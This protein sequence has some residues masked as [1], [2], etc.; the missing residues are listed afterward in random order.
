MSSRLPGF[1]KRSLEERLCTVQE[2]AGLD[3]AEISLLRENTGFGSQHADQM[4][5]N[6]IGVFPLPLGIAANFRM[7]GRDLLVPMAVEEP[8]VLAAASHA[9]NLL[10]SG[11][12][13]ETSSTDPIMIGQIQVLDF[14]GLRATRRRLEDAAEE[15]VTLANE[16]NPRLIERGGGAKRLE[17]R[18]FA[19]T[20]VGPMLVL[21]LEVDVCE[22]MGANIINTMVEAISPDVERI[23]GGRV[24]LRILSN[25]ADK[26]LVCA[27]VE[28]R[29]EGFGEVGPQ[30]H[31]WLARPESPIV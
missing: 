8:S 18:E 12:G 2:V 26:R 3:E 15:L 17:V 21:H 16:V 14:Q 29:R 10:R 20:S 19:E 7:N 31:A 22:A 9:A 5:E 4:V 28:Q 24:R 6:A 25:L 23:S 11:D 27:R 30:R 13:I 1:Y